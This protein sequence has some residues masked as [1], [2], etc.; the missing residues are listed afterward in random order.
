MSRIRI[1]VLFTILLFAA[2]SAYAKAPSK[3]E[4]DT[5]VLGLPAEATVVVEETSQKLT[6]AEA[7]EERARAEVAAAKL[8]QDAARLRLSAAESELKA[9]D[10]DGE[11]AALLN[12]GGKEESLAV[13]RTRADRTVQWRRSLLDASKLEIT[14]LNQRVSV[15]KAMVAQREAE[16][17]REKLQAWAR[18]NGGPDVE[19]A[20][21]RSFKTVANKKR[22]W[23]RADRQAGKSEKKWQK[24]IKNAEREEPEE[25]S[26][27]LLSAHGRELAARDAEVEAAKADA[28][29]VR[30]ER[31]TL[32]ADLTSARAAQAEKAA[33]LEQTRGEL[34]SESDARV[35]ELR[36]QIDQERAG[37]EAELTSLRAQIAVDAGA[38][39]AKELAALQ[40]ALA[41]SRARETELNR[42]LSEARVA[43][44]EAVRTAAGLRVQVSG[45]AEGELLAV[46]EIRDQLRAAEHAYGVALEDAVQSRDAA[47]A[48]SAREAERRAELEDALAAAQAEPAE[49]RDDLLALIASLKRQIT[50]LKDGGE[51]QVDELERRLAAMER[52]H[53]LR[54]DELAAALEDARSEGD[55]LALEAAD[56]DRRW[57]EVVRELDK[58]KSQRD[59][60]AQ[61][62]R[63]TE[64]RMADQKADFERRLD[65]LKGVA[66]EAGQKAAEVAA[67]EAE[68]DVARADA[69]REAEGLA[70]AQATLATQTARAEALEA[71]RDTLRTRSAEC[72]ADAEEAVAQ[73]AADLAAQ[74]A[75]LLATR[76]AQAELESELEM[77]KG[78]LAASEARRDRQ[79]NEAVAAA[80]AES[81]TD[82]TLRAEIEIALASAQARAAEIEGELDSI[83][84]RHQ[85]QVREIQEIESERDVALD[86]QTSAKGTVAALTRQLQQVEQASAEQVAWLRAELSGARST[87]AAQAGRIT[88]LEVALRKQERTIARLAAVPAP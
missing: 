55:T 45:A 66:S 14:H 11:S 62:V 50:A 80:R 41:S 37:Y 81:S 27:S 17:Q 79:I 63:V 16:L 31:D 64:G 24:A 5:A 67:L 10:A 61:I 77:V 68:L 70:L 3:S 51:D 83:K 42:E 22:A 53:T 86:G 6:A 1:P 58:A 40:A 21:G 47:V 23:T 85:A 59:A 7:S 15:A 74:S 48:Q 69:A 34:A 57:A 87:A 56:A 13:R 65:A 49:G 12:S 54:V 84:L 82:E 71:E 44:D 20:A 73:S 18:N 4:I 29:A 39:A 30:V 19:T 25:S 33:A 72:E 28:D 26:E 36:A 52:K 75:E 2:S 76:D 8:R 46:V 38:E 60:Q 78:Q 43:R 88:D 35:A 9:L 32:A